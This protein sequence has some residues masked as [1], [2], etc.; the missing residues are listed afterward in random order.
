MSHHGEL[1]FPFEPP[2]KRKGCN[3]LGYLHEYTGRAQGFVIPCHL[4]LTGPGH[5]GQALSCLWD[6]L[7]GLYCLG[8]MEGSCWWSLLLY[9]NVAPS[10]K[11]AAVTEDK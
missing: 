10:L 7:W 5:M 9:N 3:F 4:G 8:L 2:L 11:R 1:C 6:A